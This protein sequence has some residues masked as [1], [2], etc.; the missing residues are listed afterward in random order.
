MSKDHSWNKLYFASC[1]LVYNGIFTETRNNLYIN[2]IWHLAFRCHHWQYFGCKPQTQYSYVH[3]LTQTHCVTG[4]RPQP[5]FLN[6]GPRSPVGAAERFSWGHEQRLLLNSSA[7]VLQNPSVTILIMHQLKGA[8]N[9]EKLRTTALNKGTPVF[10]DTFAVFD[11]ANH[12]LLFKRTFKRHGHMC[13]VRMLVSWYKN[14]TLQRKLGHLYSRHHL[15]QLNSKAR[16]SLYLFARYLDERS[17]QQGQPHLNALLEIYFWI[18]CCL[19][20]Y[21]CM[22]PALLIFNAFWY[23][24]E[25]ILLKAN[26]FNCVKPLGAA[27]T[28]KIFK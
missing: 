23:F 17:G 2:I 16:V 19:L 5:G 26:F 24:A 18:I 1:Y 3:I 22:A 12:N 11:R 27:F 14:H 21:L 15:P 13:I 7:V 4:L 9:H 6:R 25:T 20:I 8:T 10:F 28:L